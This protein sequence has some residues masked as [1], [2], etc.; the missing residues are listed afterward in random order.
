MNALIFVGKYALFSAH[1]FSLIAL[2]FCFFSIEGCL[3]GYPHQMER[4]SSGEES[5]PGIMKKTLMTKHFG[6]GKAKSNIL[7]QIQNQSCRGKIQVFE[8]F[9]NLLLTRRRIHLS[10]NRNGSGL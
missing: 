8:G 3:K 5:I 10:F 7:R 4:F 6:A 9:F 1:E 2:L